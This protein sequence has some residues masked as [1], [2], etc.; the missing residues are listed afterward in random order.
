[1][2]N[3]NRILFQAC[4]SKQK[5]ELLILCLKGYKGAVPLTLTEVCSASAVVFVLFTQH[6]LASMLSSP[7]KWLSSEYKALMRKHK[8]ALI[9]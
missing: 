5:A 9:W 8:K 7:V 4:V 2:K 1:M 3:L 6:S